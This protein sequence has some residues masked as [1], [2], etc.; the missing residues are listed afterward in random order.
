MARVK[1]V[2]EDD[3]R[4]MKPLSMLLLLAAGAF[5]ILISW[6]ALANQHGQLHV[7]AAEQAG[8]GAKTDLQ[9]TAN[10]PNTV[11]VKY[12]PVIEDAQR[13]L[14]ALGV[15]KGAIDGVAGIRTKQAIATYQQMNGLPATGEATADLVNHMKFAHKVQ[16]ASQFTGS[17]API[18]ARLPVAASALPDDKALAAAK[19]Q[20][21]NVKKVQVALVSLGYD[22]TKT[23]GTESAETRAAI[24]KYEMDNGLDMSGKVD[25]GLL[26][27]LKVK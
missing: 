18:T 7:A 24:L 10:Q 20:N 23:D 27:A 12:D 14:L 9:P 17:T 26:D 21:L 25:S 6:N 22:I 13:E 16:A 3:E 1:D 4:K 5:S 11:V 19:A 15:Y 2:V 8:A